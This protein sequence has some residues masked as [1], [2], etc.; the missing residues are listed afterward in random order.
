LWFRV[1]LLKQRVL[2]W[3]GC[4]KRSRGY[5]LSRYTPTLPLWFVEFDF[6]IWFPSKTW[7]DEF[8]HSRN[9]RINP[10]LWQ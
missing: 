7:D 9:L 6:F 5:S 1:F 8:S 4:F 10:M 2:I 3:R